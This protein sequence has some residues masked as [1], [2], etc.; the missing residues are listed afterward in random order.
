MFFWAKQLHFGCSIA[1]STTETMQQSWIWML[2]WWVRE[3]GLFTLWYHNYVVVLV[4][5]VWFFF[6]GGGCVSFLLCFCLLLLLWV[7]GFFLFYF[8]VAVVGFSWKPHSVSDNG[9]RLLWI[10]PNDKKQNFNNCNQSLF[11]WGMLPQ[12]TPQS[13]PKAPQFRDTHCPME[14]ESKWPFF[15]FSKTWVGSRNYPHFYF[16]FKIKVIFS[17]PFSPFLPFLC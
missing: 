14:V 12:S 7:L 1:I 8:V 3:G 13:E 9:I 11:C 5:F 16:Y 17:I 6:W 2:S 15:Y 10:L 4:L